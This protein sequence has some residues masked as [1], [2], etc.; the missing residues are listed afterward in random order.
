MDFRE[1]LKRGTEREKGNGSNEMMT[2]RGILSKQN[3]A[4]PTTLT[5]RKILAFE[6]EK[7]KYQNYFFRFSLKMISRYLLN[8]ILFIQIPMIYPD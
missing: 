3:S 2:R 4:K 5:D 6:A 8:E 7:V 1:N